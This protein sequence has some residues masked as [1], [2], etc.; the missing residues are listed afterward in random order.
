M[1]EQQ[2]VLTK[3][4][5]L[6]L[7]GAEFYIDNFEERGWLRGYTDGDTILIFEWENFP[8]PGAEDIP[9]NGPLTV[10]IAINGIKKLWPVRVA[11]YG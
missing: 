5:D 7:Q 11:T 4:V 2:K 1:T 8:F 10:E 6:A 3:I 9:G